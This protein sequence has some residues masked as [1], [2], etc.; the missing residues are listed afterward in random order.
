MRVIFAGSP[1][2]AV[3][4]LERLLS[5]DHEIVGVVTQP[6]RPAGRGLKLKPPPVKEVAIRSGLPVWQPEKF[7]SRSFLDR[8]AEMEPDLIVVAAYGKIFRRRSLALPRLGC[9]NLHASL[10]PFY[11]GIAPVNWA[12][13]RGERETGVTTI[14]MDEGVDTGDMILQSSVTIGEEQTAGEVL[15]VL[16]VLGAD[17]MAETCNL[18][19]HG[20]APRAKQDEKLATYAPRLSKQ[21]GWI[22]WD[23]SSRELHNL[24]RGVTPWPGAVATYRTAAVKILR[25][26]PATE[27]PR[28]P[29]T[30]I[31]IDPAAG[32]LV[33]CAEGS[34]WLLELQAQGKRALGGADF[35]RGHRIKVGDSFGSKT[36]ENPE[37]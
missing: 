19:A 35:A 22:R 32:I 16:A 21:D 27:A 17:V 23:V 18:I 15:D 20:E 11:R 36:D 7:N 4:T 24:V 30:V 8:L 1:A 14:F 2:F 6:D 31:G 5:S 29:G 34:V 12:V 26:R 28:E 13:I 33:S 3:P 10:L 9:V 37:G 25:T